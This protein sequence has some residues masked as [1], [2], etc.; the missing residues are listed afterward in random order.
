MKF[1]G[2]ARAVLFAA[3]VVA[4]AAGLGFA[5]LP[6][7]AVTPHHGG[8]G[9]PQITLTAGGDRA[10][11]NSVSGLGGVR[12]R[13]QHASP[14]DCTTGSNGKCTLTVFAGD[15]LVHQES[16]P[17]GW[18]LSPQLGI[19]PNSNSTSVVVK[20]YS[21]LT[22]HV[23]PPGVAVPPSTSGTTTNPYA[24]SG[25][26]AVSRNNPPLPPHCGLNVAL[27]FDLSASVDG[28]LRELQDAGIGFVNS[29]QGTPTS[30][31]LYTMGTHAPVNLTNNSNF[32]LTPLTTQSN[33]SVLTSKIRGY[34][35]V[36][37]PAQYT[38]WDAGLWQIANASGQ[39]GSRQV[40]YDAVIVL[41]HGDPT[42][43]GP[44]ASGRP[45]RRSPGSSTS[46]TRSSPPTC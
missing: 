9:N 33:V 27:L 42:V 30:V 23:P 7:L 4:E 21:S 36:S 26:W 8:G 13:E 10:T 38:N 22:V 37:N 12:F 16:A 5:V 32:P 2:A 44:A 6:A 24:R 40:H 25:G 17:S 20:D 18:Y 45:T 46:R 35:I 14:P 34:T 1:P 3:A 41:N 28:H 29:L 39:P 43:Y 11:S 15:H 31:A 19:S